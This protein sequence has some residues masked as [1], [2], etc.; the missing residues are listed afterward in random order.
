MQSE[1]V[2][3]TTAS[4]FT[5]TFSYRR[6]VSVGDA[7]GGAS[8]SDSD[9]DSWLVNDLDGPADGQIPCTFALLSMRESFN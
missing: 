8:L 2:A 9:D 1:G 6:K 3:F 5:D 4:L 7:E